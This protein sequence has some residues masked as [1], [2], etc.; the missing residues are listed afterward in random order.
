MDVRR[1]RTNDAREIIEEIFRVH[2]RFRPELFV[3]EQE[4]IAKSIGGFLESEQ[5]RRGIFIN[6]EK[7]TVTQDKRKRARSIQARFRSGGIRVDKKAPWYP[8]FYQE[9]IQFDRGKYQDQVDA[10]AHIGLILDK[11]AEVPTREQ[12]ADMEY[13]DEY[14]ETFGSF[15]PY[16]EG[17]G[18]RNSVTGY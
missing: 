7:P 10:L 14:E 5:L 12:I 11:M 6:L 13:E 1:F 16:E 3:I 2:T 17:F 15:V 18:D 9:L 8:E 4:N